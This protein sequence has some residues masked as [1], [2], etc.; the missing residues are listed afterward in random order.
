MTID[1]PITHYSHSH[2]S[3][4]L[5]DTSSCHKLY[6]LLMLLPNNTCQK[7]K[8]FPLHFTK[9]MSSSIWLSSASSLLLLSSSVSTLPL[10]LLLETG[11]SLFCLK[12]EV[13]WWV[14][15]WWRTWDWPRIEEKRWVW[16]WS[17]GDPSGWEF[18]ISRTVIV[19]SLQKGLKLFGN[20]NI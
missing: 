6:H 9:K 19:F 12:R 1:G 8:L 10:S 20:Q 15:W 14:Q 16:W 3:Q 7:K 13:S 18:I 5:T 11:N 2:L 4:L 17:G